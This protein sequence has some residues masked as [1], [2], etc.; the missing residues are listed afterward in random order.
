MKF[1]EA[2]VLLAAG[3]VGGIFST[4]VSI[5]SLVTYPALLALGVPPLSANM[6]NTVSL[7]LTG[8]GSVLSSKPELADQKTRVIR[9]AIVTALGGAAGAAVLLLTPASTFTVVVPVLIGGASL[10]L[11]VQPRIRRLAPAPD[12]NRLAQGAALF[13]VAVYVGYF[14][15][16]A[17]VM[18]LVVLSVMIDEPLITVNAV[19]NA[20]SG[21][22]NLTAAVC[23]AL[24]GDVRWALV[25]PLAAGFLAGGLIGPKI[26]RR[27]PA[28]PFRVVVSL[29]GIGLAVRLGISAYH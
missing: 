4:V 16:A 10:V 26:V 20:V 5:A 18:L 2:L 6:T 1:S 21:A 29:C 22:A 27:V 14:G 19:K 11:L 3:T 17:G 7:V 13:T 23:F 24:F 9:L 8:A 15:A 12:G 25:V 28:G